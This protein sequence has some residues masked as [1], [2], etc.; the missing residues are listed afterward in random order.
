VGVPFIGAEDL[1]RLLPMGAAI[2]ALE[3]AFGGGRLPEAPLRSSV[4]TSAGSLYLMPSHG[5]QGVGMEQELLV[6]GA[7][8]P[9]G[10]RLRAR[11]DPGDEVIARAD[12]GARC[13]V[14]SCG[15]RV[16][17]VGGLS[18]MPPGRDGGVPC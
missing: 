15:H 17:L 3:A 12:G 13:A 5:P 10:A 11:R 6:L 14:L 8:A 4:D 9:L 7:D 1:A 2:D 18:P 16:V